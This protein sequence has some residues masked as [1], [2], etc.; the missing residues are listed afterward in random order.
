MNERAKGYVNIY[1]HIG[2]KDKR[3]VGDSGERQTDRQ[4]DRDKERDRERLTDRFSGK[5]E[6]DRETQRDR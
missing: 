6:T 4:T 5:R 2:M 3:G 1:A